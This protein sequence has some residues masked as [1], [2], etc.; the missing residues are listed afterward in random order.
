M[1]LD[2]VSGLAKGRRVAKH[3]ELKI[4]KSSADERRSSLD[5]YQLTA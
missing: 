4:P 3:M 2:Q 1:N 5:K